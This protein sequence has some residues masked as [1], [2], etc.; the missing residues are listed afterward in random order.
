MAG[1]VTPPEFGFLATTGLPEEFGFLF[2]T[3]LPLDFVGL[4]ISFF[5]QVRQLIRDLIMQIQYPSMSPR[6]SM[7]TCYFIYS[8]DRGKNTGFAQD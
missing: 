3:A 2:C 6:S 1:E 4:F 8:I 5:F 7:T